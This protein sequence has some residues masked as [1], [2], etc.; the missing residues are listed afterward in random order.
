MEKR[1]IIHEKKEKSIKN[2]HPWIYSGAVKSFP[3][4]EDGE[5]LPV[6]SSGGEMLGHA[7][8]NK[9]CSLVGRMV[10]FGDTDPL[11]S[12]RENMMRAFRSRE[13]H[14]DDRITNCYRLINAEGDSLPGLV[15]D[16]YN[17]VVVV[18]ISTLGMERLK[19]L[20][21]D[22]IKSHHFTKSLFFSLN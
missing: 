16:R 21:V 20:V 11:V 2:R 10:N 6:V 13:R 17:N 12:L 15:A 9:R 14:F 19:P 18:Q 7:Y 22:I 4:F 8:F 1:V 5:I 3:S